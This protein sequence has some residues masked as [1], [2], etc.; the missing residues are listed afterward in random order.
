MTVQNVEIRASEPGDVPVIERLYPA[1]FPE[2][3]LLPVVKSLLATPSIVL[4]LVAIMESQVA[5]HVAFTACNVE[6]SDA[7]VALLAPLA[8]A[9]AV[10]RQGIGTALV[11]AGVR[12]LEENGVSKVFVLGDPA[13]YGRHGFEREP[14]VEAPYP[15]PEQWRDAWQSMGLGDNDRPG[16]GKLIVPELWKKPEL[17]S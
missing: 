1:A 7:K 9:P 2:E 15:I 4:S 11:R 3:D 5:G 12:H 6:G 13:Y 16:T 17:W 10:Q 14:L 8:V